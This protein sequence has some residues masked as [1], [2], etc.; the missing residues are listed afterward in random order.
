MGFYH[1]RIARPVSSLVK[2]REMYCQGLGLQPIGAFDNHA[3]FSG[4]MLGRAEMPWHLEFTL[5][6]THPVIPAPSQE[7][8]LVIYIAEPQAW[9]RA[10]D[11][12]RN[13]AFNPYWDNEGQ[14]FVDHDGYRTVI[15][16]RAWPPQTA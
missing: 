3:G 5:C 16:Q 12:M 15:Q 6:L 2:S 7:D 13:A 4:V 8:L 10:C 1:L 11:A 14:T 9:R